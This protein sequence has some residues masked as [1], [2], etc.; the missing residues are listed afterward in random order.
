[1]DSAWKSA[2]KE[3]IQLIDDNPEVLFPALQQVKL[4]KGV[5]HNYNT[6]RVKGQGILGTPCTEEPWPETYLLN[7]KVPS[8]WLAHWLLN[9]V[10]TVAS[11]ELVNLVFQKDSNAVRMLHEYATGI[12]PSFAMPKQMRNKVIMSRV[13]TF[14]H[15][16][17]GNRLMDVFQN[18]VDEDGTVLWAGFPVYSWKL[19]D[20][21]V[22]G[23]VHCSGTVALVGRR[24]LTNCLH[25]GEQAAVMIV[26]LTCLDRFVQ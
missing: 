4:L 15:R 2:K 1:M 14:R 26:M 22:V 25:T 7:R 3:L 5:T 6:H 20:N 19:E 9:E 10:K 13:Y 11:A 21:R 18:H 8:Y 24:R 17:L 16:F 12:S 23:V